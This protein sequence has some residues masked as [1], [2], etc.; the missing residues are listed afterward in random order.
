[1]G[2]YQLPSFKILSDRPRHG[3]AYLLEWDCNESS[4]AGMPGTL[5]EAA[6][7]VS[8]LSSIHLLLTSSAVGKQPW[9]VSETGLSGTHVLHGRIRQRY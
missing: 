9:I 3:V 7:I 8:L 2:Q 6:S 4:C 1:M 5:L